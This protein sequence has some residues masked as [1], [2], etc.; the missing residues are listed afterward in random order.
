MAF[1]HGHP[2]TSG[3]HG[4][5]YFVSSDLF[6]TATSVDAREVRRF[7]GAGIDT[8][9]ANPD[10][11]VAFAATTEPDV[12]TNCNNKTIRS[13]KHH[14]PAETDATLTSARHH[15]AWSRVMQPS[16]LLS[17]GRHS[18][19]LKQGYGDGTQDYTE[20][21]V[22]FDSLTASLSDAQILPDHLR[23]D[24]ALSAKDVAPG[25]GGLSHIKKGEH[26]YHCIQ[27]SKKFHPAFDAVLRGVLLGDPAAKILLTAAS[28]VCRGGNS[29]IPRPSMYAAA[30]IMKRAMPKSKVLGTRKTGLVDTCA[31]STCTTLRYRYPNIASPRRNLRLIR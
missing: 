26:A 24:A 31:S 30:P 4:I 21:L 1:G 3:S 17:E 16:L 27:H 25:Y 22:L 23:D 6:E 19:C 13:Q 9:D 29:F 18:Q 5:D 20:Q 10:N 7:P 15:L 14:P 8:L 2:V 12:A 28:K 11:Y